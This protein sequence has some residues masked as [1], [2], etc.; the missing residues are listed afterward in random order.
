MAF[1]EEQKKCGGITL[2][3]L[4]TLI[5]GG[6]MIAVGAAHFQSGE[7]SEAQEPCMK[8]IPIAMMVGGIIFIGALVM[9]FVIQVRETMIYKQGDNKVTKKE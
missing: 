3:G 6:G 4:F 1:D 5:L 2:G 7:V 8:C 9:R